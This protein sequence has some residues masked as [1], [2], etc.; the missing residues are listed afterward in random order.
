MWSEPVPKLSS[1]HRDSF[2][3]SIRLPKYFHP[4]GTS[5]S[6]KPFASA[7]LKH[8]KSSIKKIQPNSRFHSVRTNA[9]QLCLNQ[10]KLLSNWWLWDKRNM[11]TPEFFNKWYNIALKPV[12]ADQRCWKNQLKEVFL[13]YLL[14]HPSKTTFL[15][16]YHVYPPHIYFKGNRKL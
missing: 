13:F 15:P 16:L 6:D 9:L 1:P 5:Y 14:I 4:V 8:V 11:G 2:P 12:K 7:T 10:K 3:A